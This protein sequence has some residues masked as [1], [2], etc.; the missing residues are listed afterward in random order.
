MSFE[1]RAEYRNSRLFGTSKC[2]SYLGKMFS[3]A[4]QLR[5]K[6]N[7][8]VVKKKTSVSESRSWT[9]QHSKKKSLNRL[10][11]RSLAR[12]LFGYHSR[13]QNPL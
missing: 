10:L 4:D 2:A 9:Q 6:Q 7:K 12:F 5:K 8:N 1:I 13:C 11:D 3:E